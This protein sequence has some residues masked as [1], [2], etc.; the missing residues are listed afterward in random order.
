MATKP[1]PAGESLA[2]ALRPLLRSR[3]AR[4][5]IGE[6]MA[7]IEVGDGLGPVLFVLTLPVLLP[8]PPGVSMVAALPLLI[9]APQ[10]M[11][12]RRFV[13]LPKA[14]SDKTLDRR[15]LAKLLRRVLPMVKRAEKVVKPRLRFLT[16][17]LGAG[18][19]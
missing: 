17:R 1:K 11:I 19:V 8:L 15:E 3:K 5:T 18:I 10:I 9:V 13:W 4:L 2:A 14:L 12:G 16:G 6:M 7:R